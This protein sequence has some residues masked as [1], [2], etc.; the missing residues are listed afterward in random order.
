LKSVVR[1]V[2]DVVEKTSTC[3]RSGIPTV[4]VEKITTRRHEDSGVVVDKKFKKSTNYQ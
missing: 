3:R 4:F 2:S 1:V